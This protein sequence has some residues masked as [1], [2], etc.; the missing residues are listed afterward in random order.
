M[1]KHIEVV[2]FSIGLLA[3][4]GSVG[5]LAETATGTGDW[6]ASEHAWQLQLLFE[7]RASQLKSEQRGRVFIYSDLTDSVVDRAM[8]EAFDRIEHMMFVRTVRTDENG[9]VEMAVN[10]D[11]EL[12]AVVE[13]DGC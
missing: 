4:I 7:P 13:D 11:G 5:S 9:E 8:D 3:G 6:D 10:N 1:F 2:T 12:V